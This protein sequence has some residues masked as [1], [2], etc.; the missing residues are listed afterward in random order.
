MDATQDNVSNQNFP[1]FSTY[2]IINSCVP[3]SIKPK[4]LHLA[5]YTF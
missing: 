5:Q 4:A 3:G 1:T 2:K